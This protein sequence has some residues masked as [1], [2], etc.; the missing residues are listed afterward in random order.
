MSVPAELTG[1]WQRAGLIVD[2]VRCVDACDV[3]WLQSPDWYAD[4]RLPRP[5]REV[6]STGPA[7]AFAAAW[8]FGG[9]ADWDPPVMT[10]HHSFDSRAGVTPDANPLVW[11]EGLLVERGTFQWAGQGLRFEEEWRRL[12]PAGAGTTADIGEE[13]IVV[14][15]DRWRITID[16]RRPDHP[17]T[18][19][20]Q[21]ERDGRWLT[22][23][24]VQEPDPGHRGLIGT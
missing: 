11:E 7:A 19:V 15:V 17:F 22:I 13:R 3:I 12:S 24:F 5:D 21:E 20:R 10:W 1:A 4:I 6:S 16:D 14:R 2:G 9:T 8:A 18:A 23:G